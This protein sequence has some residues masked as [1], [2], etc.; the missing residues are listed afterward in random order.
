MQLAAKGYLLHTY[1]QHFCVK[2]AARPKAAM[3]VP[4]SEQAIETRAA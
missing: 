3:P 1:H 4:T 2:G